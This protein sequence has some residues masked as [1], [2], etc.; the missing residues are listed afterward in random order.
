MEHLEVCGRSDTG[1]GRSINEDS[2]V[3]I[4]IGEFNLLAVA[5]GLGGHAAGEVASKIAVIEIGEFLKKNLAEQGPSEAFKGA[6]EKANKEIYLL[7]RENQVY[8]G[9]GSTVVAALV[10]GHKALIANVGDSRAYLVDGGLEQVTRDH[11]LVQELV[12]K[13]IITKEEAIR[14][15]QRH[16][17]TR[18]LGTQDIVVP[19]FK[20]KDLEGK[21]LLLCSDGLTDSLKEEEIRDTVLGSA[22]LDRGCVNLIDV[23]NQK[24]A[25]DNITV[26]LARQS[27]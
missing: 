18:T 24:G 23:A 9:M 17:V 27:V 20:E 22:E 21:T 2:L 15:P 19:D 10:Q 16:V 13:G 7:S 11:S 6:I 26:I 25:S 3:T 14:H 1:K 4:E 8:A 12:D 5:D